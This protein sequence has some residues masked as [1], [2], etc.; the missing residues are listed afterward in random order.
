M[1]PHLYKERSP[2][3]TKGPHVLEAF[4]ELTPASSTWHESGLALAT[5]VRTIGQAYIDYQ[6]ERPG[7]D[8]P[9]GYW[10]RVFDFDIEVLGQTCS[11]IAGAIRTMRLERRVHFEPPGPDPGPPGPPGLQIPPL[12]P[13]YGG[14]QLDAMQPYYYLPAGLPGPHEGYHAGHP[15]GA[16]HS[17]PLSAKAMENAVPT[18]VAS[19]TLSSMGSSILKTPPRRPR[20]EDH[21]PKIVS[22]QD[23]SQDPSVPD[24]EEVAGKGDL[25]HELLAH[26]SAAIENSKELLDLAPSTRRMVEDFARIGDTDPEGLE[27]MLAVLLGT[28]DQ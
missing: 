19:T 17:L 15:G 1:I 10:A 21:E 7:I 6:R 5:F 27:K 26:K 11:R 4:Y 20:A 2:L 12:P 13:Y 25:M 22:S 16:M 14:P 3:K 23:P 9:N 8:L 28:D 24:V 18:M